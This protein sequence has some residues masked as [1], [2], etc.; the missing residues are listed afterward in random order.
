MSHDDN[1][2]RFVVGGNAKLASHIATFSL[3]A[4]YSCPGALKCLAKAD[5]GS[6]KITDG[7]AQEFRC[8]AASHECVYPNVRKL[9]W[10]NYELLM[11]ASTKDAMVKLIIESIPDET[12]VLRIHVSGDFFS[13]EYFDAWAEVA[14]IKHEILFYAYTMS[15]HFWIARII[16]VPNN[17]ILIASRGGRY[18]HLIDRFDL[19]EA[20]A[21]FSPEDAAD[22]GLEIDH[23]DSHAYDKTKSSFA[24]LLHG[25]QKSGSKA[26]EAIQNMKDNNVDFAYNQDLANKIETNVSNQT[27]TNIYKNQEV[28]I[29]SKTRPIELSHGWAEIFLRKS[30]CSTPQNDKQLN[31]EDYI[32][33]GGKRHRSAT[34][35]YSWHSARNPL[36]L[37]RPEWAGYTL[38]ADLRHA[39]ETDRCPP[40]VMDESLRMSLVKNPPPFP[41]RTGSAP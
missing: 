17:F 2:L 16:S 41:C 23:D 11:K 1:K 34:C 6:G 27:E 9:R 8:Y 37:N 13:Q 22:M 33:S 21:V 14:A 15:L 28:Q 26:A 38:V 32:A 31:P 24:L 3:P 30:S 20:V 36:R 5:P 12:K 18:S 35:V 39:F 29:T 7:P 4:G 10:Y 25:Q 40:M 19:K